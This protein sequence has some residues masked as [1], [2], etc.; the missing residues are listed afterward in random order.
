VGRGCNE[1]NAEADTGRINGCEQL[2]AGAKLN[3]NEL[4]AEQ[5]AE[6]HTANK[7]PAQ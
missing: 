2:T 6:Q 4:R 3:P 1:Q 7:H 5:P